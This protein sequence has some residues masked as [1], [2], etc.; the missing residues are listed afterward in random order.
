MPFIEILECFSSFVLT[1]ETQCSGQKQTSVCQTSSLHPAEWV[2]TKPP[3]Q[4]NLR[5]YII[6]FSYHPFSFKTNWFDYTLDWVLTGT[7]SHFQDLREDQPA[8]PIIEWG[9]LFVPFLLKFWSVF[10]LSGNKSSRNS[11]RWICQYYWESDMATITITNRYQQV[12]A[13][14]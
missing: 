12:G 14:G 13:R 1:K 7:T 3:N 2:E 6:W 9:Q 11:Q 5:V 10:F 4:H 8:W